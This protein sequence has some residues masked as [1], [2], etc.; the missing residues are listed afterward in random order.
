MAASRLGQGL[1]LCST[2]ASVLQAEA[3]AAVARQSPSV[4]PE[5]A[6]LWEGVVVG[7]AS[8]GPPQTDVPPVAYACLF[9]LS[10]AT[11]EVAQFLLGEA[12]P[13]VEALEVDDTEAESGASREGQTLRTHLEAEFGGRVR[14]GARNYVRPGLQAAEAA[15]AS[16]EAAPRPWCDLVVYSEAAPRFA[17]ERILGRLRSHVVVA[18]VSHPCV[19]DEDAIPTPRCNR[20]NVIWEK[21]SL[22]K[23]G[24]CVGAV[25]MARVPSETLKDPNTLPIDCKRFVDSEGSQAAV[26]EF[27]QDWFVHQN[28][29]R[30]GQMGGDTEHA[31]LYV[32]VGASL[33]FEY[34]NTVVLDRCLGWQGIC[35]EPNPHI[36]A[37]LEAHRSCEVV[38]KCVSEERVRGKPF[39]D[40]DGEVM[41]HANCSPLW[42]ILDR[43]GARHRRIHVLSIDVEHG[44]LGV[45]RGL[46][47]DQ[48]DVR[49][50]VVEVTKGARWLEVD[51]IILPHGYA[52]VAVL[53]RDVVYVKLEELT[54]GSFATN[55]QFLRES[56]GHRALATLPPNWADFHQR[57]VDEELHAEAVREKEASE[58]GLRRR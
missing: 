13:R 29:F 44:E 25:C 5:F 38:P 40:R 39:S 49:V 55:W 56:S 6:R 22:F 51:T 11:F 32:D 37:F 41:F 30:G 58:R 52:K 10:N 15:E 9:G 8:Q 19:M 20:V 33:P 17:L 34:S 47:L 24:Y 48:F 31:P 7:Q 35:V 2:A 26:A 3:A 27:Q 18:L 12:Q 1:W 23:W 36:V 54:S 42:E 50:I 57:V 46:P 16:E 21:T 4:L 28:F 45:L 14:P 43:A 53:G